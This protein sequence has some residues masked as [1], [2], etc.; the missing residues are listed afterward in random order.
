MDDA[1]L[2]NDV[3]EQFKATVERLEGT[4]SEVAYLVNAA[5]R[6][7]LLERGIRWAAM[8]EQQQRDAVMDA[9][10]TMQREVRLSRADDSVGED[11]TP[12]PDEEWEVAWMRDEH[13]AW[14][15]TVVIEG[16]PRAL[17]IHRQIGIGPLM[18]AWGPRVAAPD[19]EDRGEPTPDPESAREPGDTIHYV[20][21]CT[22]IE[23]TA[24][25]ADITV[26][27]TRRCNGKYRLRH[28]RPDEQGDS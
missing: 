16:I 5:G 28:I 25:R 13:G 8:T 18:V 4:I 6:G 15:P 12:P 17:T 11:C 26:R 20:I 3:V 14:R 27:N 9:I 22:R 1:Q 7:T 10:L 21:R 24:D 2:D 23:D 19:L